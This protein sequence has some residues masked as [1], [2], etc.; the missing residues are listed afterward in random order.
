[1]HGQSR[2]DRGDKKRADHV[3]SA[4]NQGNDNTDERHLAKER[5]RDRLM[6]GRG[7]GPQNQNRGTKPDGNGP[8]PERSVH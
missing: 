4:V 6:I 1:M 8:E 5:E 2:E 3:F 7:I